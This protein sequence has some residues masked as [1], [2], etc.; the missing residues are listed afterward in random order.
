MQATR[1]E[2]MDCATASAKGGREKTTVIVQE[3]AERVAGCDPVQKEAVMR[4]RDAA[5]R[6]RDAA[7]REREEMQYNAE[8]HK[9]EAQ[10]AVGREKD[11]R[12][13]ISPVDADDAGVSDRPDNT[14]TAAQDAAE[15]PTTTTKDA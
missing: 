1:E 3:Q 10:D 2:K 8:M 11:A 7:M 14:N 6:E 12:Y 15:D 5:A 9:R 13:D 4:E